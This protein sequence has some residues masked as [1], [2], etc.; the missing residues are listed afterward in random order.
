[1]SIESAEMSVLLFSARAEAIM[2]GPP[3]GLLDRLADALEK[4]A[5]ERVC[6]IRERDAAR[7]REQKM[8]DVLASLRRGHDT[9]ED[10][11]YSCPKSPDGCA[12]DGAGD[13]CNCGAD[14]HNAIIDNALAADTEGGAQ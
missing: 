8:R 9:C 11:W 12:N 10:S 7:A 14:A 4:V 1:M 13:D 2:S 5:I 3:G 6:V